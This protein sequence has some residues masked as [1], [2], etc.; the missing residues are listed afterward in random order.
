MSRPTSVA[1]AQA[2]SR[3]EREA[4]TKRTYA[5]DT[6]MHRA[7]LRHRASRGDE[8]ARAALDAYAA[9]HPEPGEEE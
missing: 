4:R 5:T 6:A 7:G 9:A 1:A 3:R 2:A 8:A